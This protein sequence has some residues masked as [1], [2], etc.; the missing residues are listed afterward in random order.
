MQRIAEGLVQLGHRVCIITTRRRDEAAQ[1]SWRGVS[2]YRCFTV[3]V[4]GFYQALPLESTIEKILLE[5]AVQLVHHHYLGLLLRRAEMVAH[6]LGLRQVYTYHMTVDHLTQPLPMRPLRRWLSRQIVDYCNKFDLII[7]PS[8]NLVDRIRADGIRTP[9]RYITNPVVCE[10]VGA[11]EPAPRTAEFMVLFAG[12]LD[13]EKNIPLLL[14][15]LRRM[16]DAG[17]DAGLWI[18]GA[19]MQRRRLEAL[20]DSLG[21]RSKVH[22]IGFVKHAQL[23]RYYAACDTFVLPSLVETQGLVAM[24]AMHFGRPVIVTRAIVS[25]TELVAEGQSGFIVDP[26]DPAEL[27]DRLLTLAADPVLRE[28][29]GRAGSARARAFAPGAVIQATDDAYRAVLR[30]G[31]RGTPAV[32]AA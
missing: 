18:A 20:C 23:A 25:A 13:P 26:S 17:R 31:D 10:P 11:V 24:E 21:I 28:R 9:I 19:G 27:A 12:R 14:N 6:R 7:S 2:V 8:L 5:N 1:E 15:A 22:F 32:E 3:R 16:L 30:A 4:F 29:L